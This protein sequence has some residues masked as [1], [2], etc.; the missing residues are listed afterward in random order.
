MNPNYW[1]PLGILGIEPNAT[2]YVSGIYLKALR[3]VG[4]PGTGI[5]LAFFESLS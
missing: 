3:A 2:K 4:K 1:G 5:R